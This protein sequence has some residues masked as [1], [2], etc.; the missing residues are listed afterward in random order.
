ME[1]DNIPPSMLNK[2]T[3]KQYTLEN[4]VLEYLDRKMYS[5]K[6]VEYLKKIMK[7]E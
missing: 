3:K 1:L 6:I 4:L 2:S 7:K 5:E